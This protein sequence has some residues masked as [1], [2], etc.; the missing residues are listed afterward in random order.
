MG[1]LLIYK[2]KSADQGGALRNLGRQAKTFQQKLHK[3]GERIAPWLISSPK[4]TEH[5]MELLHQC[6]VDAEHWKDQA[7]A[8]EERI[9]DK[10]MQLDSLMDEFQF[11]IK[12]LRMLPLRNH[13]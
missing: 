13:L 10:P 3:V 2:A 12:Q 6:H 1:E 8:L 9:S 11:K 4:E 7:H 5:V